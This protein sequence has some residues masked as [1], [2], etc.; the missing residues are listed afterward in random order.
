MILFSF[1]EQGP[2]A[3]HDDEL[4][5]G[6]L[7][8]RWAVSIEKWS[9]EILHQCKYQEGWMPGLGYY[10]VGVDPR[11]LS[12]GH[13]KEWYDGMHNVLWIGPLYVNWLSL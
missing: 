3:G 2:I 6:I 4:N 13:R 11:T 5:T 9:V 12:F 8:R 10:T 7:G 1:K